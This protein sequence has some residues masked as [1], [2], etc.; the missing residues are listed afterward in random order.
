MVAQ[1]GLGRGLGQGRGRGRGR[2]G[3]P[4][5]AGPGGNCVCTNPSC[6]NEVP[7]M[8]GQPCY[9]RK[10]PKCSSPMVRKE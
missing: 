10:C 2:M 7:H 9:Q 8:A 4:L 1:R 6:K 3:G 5:S